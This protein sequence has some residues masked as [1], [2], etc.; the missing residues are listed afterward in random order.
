ATS[1]RG[2]RTRRS[3]ALWSSAAPS[4]TAA[5]TLPLPAALPIFQRGIPL[6][7]GDHVNRMTAGDLHD[8]LPG[9]SETI[10]GG[11]TDASRAGHFLQ[12][13]ARIFRQGQGQRADERF[14]GS[15]EGRLAGHGNAV[16]L[17]W[18][19]RLRLSVPQMLNGLI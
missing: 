9:G 6:N 17:L 5:P 7:L 4:S 12:G 18:S 1:A 2:G 10:Q 19:L 8:L 3:S 15:A 11:A 13:G 16:P 14:F